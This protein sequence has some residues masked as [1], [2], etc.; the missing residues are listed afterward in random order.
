MCDQPSSGLMFKRIR[1]QL[2]KKKYWWRRKRREKGMDIKKGWIKRKT[3]MSGYSDGGSMQLT[4][5][6]YSTSDTIC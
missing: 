6:L 4:L 1:K 3:V 5:G 2:K